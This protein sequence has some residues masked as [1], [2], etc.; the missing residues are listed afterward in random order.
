MIIYN[1]SMVLLNAYIV[2]EVRRK[3]ICLRS[4][5]TGVMSVLKAAGVVFFFGF[6]FLFLFLHLVYDVWMGHHLHMEMRPY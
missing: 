6:F 1:V 3:G 2:Y 5:T 4:F